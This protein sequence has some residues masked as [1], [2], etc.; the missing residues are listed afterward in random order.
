[1]PKRPDPQFEFVR[2]VTGFRAPTALVVRLP[3]RLRRKQDLLRA[4]S[5]ALKFP[6][7]FGNNWDS[8]DECLRDLSW[9]GEQKSIAL[10]HEQLPLSDD[11]QRRVYIDILHSAQKTGSIPL[12]VIFP[13]SARGQIDC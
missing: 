7:Y 10:V 4:L 12:R 11:K 5:A 6:P 9:L 1:M 3:G 8:L 13:E 2:D